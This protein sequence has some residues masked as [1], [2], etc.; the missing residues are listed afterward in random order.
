MFNPQ[1]LGS[2]SLTGWGI[3][4]AG[5]ELWQLWERGWEDVVRCPKELGNLQPGCPS[6]V[7]SSWSSETG[8]HILTLTTQRIPGY[9]EK[10]LW[11][12]GCCQLQGVIPRGSEPRLAGR[13][14]PQ[15]AGRNPP[16]LKDWLRIGRGW[17]SMVSYKGTSGETSGTPKTSDLWS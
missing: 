10:R 6:D 12:C 7:V 17:Y 3:V 5:F 16:V 15:A 14:H 1:H 9:P 2:L 13:W 11:S 4:K 8:P